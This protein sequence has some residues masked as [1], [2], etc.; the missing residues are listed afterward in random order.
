MATNLLLLFILSPFLPFTSSR[1][2]CPRIFFQNINEDTMPYKIIEGVFLKNKDDRNSFPVYRRED[3]NLLF[4]HTVSKGNNYLVFG[5]NLNDHF[6]VAA[7]L[8]R[9]RSPSFWLRFGILDRNDV[10]GGIV[11][12]WQYYN[13]R[14]QTNYYVST[15]YSSPMIKAVCVDEDFRECNSDRVY[16]IKSFNDERGNN[17]NNPTTDYF[18][19]TEGLFRN[20]RPVYKHSAQTLYLQ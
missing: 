5:L 8:Y 18:Y 14:E 10:F 7:V 6:G 20:L 1:T 3:D 9:Q 11:N 16:L 15:I 12:Q 4:Y 2:L 19:R 17:L 13:T